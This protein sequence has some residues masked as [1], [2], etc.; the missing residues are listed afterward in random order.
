MPS[1][2]DCEPS[3]SAVVEVMTGLTRVPEFVFRRSSVER[4]S[5]VSAAGDDRVTIDDRFGAVGD[6]TP[7]PWSSATEMTR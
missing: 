4:I 7:S 3:D 6:T 5:V 2:S 1:L